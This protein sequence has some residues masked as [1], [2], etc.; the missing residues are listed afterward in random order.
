MA[1]RPFLFEHRDFDQLAEAAAVPANERPQFSQVELEG[2]VTGAQ[3]RG[4]EEGLANAQRGIESNL[5]RLL[6]NALNSMQELHTQE[7]ARSSKAQ[8]LAIEIASGLLRKL[9]PELATQQSLEGITALVK[10]VM[11]D[12]FEEP[13]LIIRVH[14]SMIDPL[15]ARLESLAAQNGFRGQY[16]LMAD[17][18]LGHADCRIE[19]SN[20]GVERSVAR[21]WDNL[22]VSLAQIQAALLPH[23]T[24][25]PS[26]P[27]AN[28]SE[29]P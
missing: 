23:D 26:P 2:A 6:E 7:A 29:T 9:M 20:G 28:E 13:R 11:M 27:P 14:D 16:A 8:A 5:T 25:L 22:Q 4:F 12:R 15:S 18:A 21:L 17:T 1:S 10:Q 24:I 3:Q 19:W